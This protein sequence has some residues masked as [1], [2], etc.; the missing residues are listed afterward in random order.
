MFHK[1]LLTLTSGA[2]ALTLLSVQPAL[3]QESG[4]DGRAGQSGGA[5]RTERGPRQNRRAS[6]AATPT[7]GENAATV[8]AMLTTASV[9]CRVLEATLVGVTAEEHPTYEASCVDG[10]GYLVIGATPPQTFNCL[11]LAGQAETSRLRDPEADVGQQCTLPVN[12]DPLPVLSGYARQAGIDCTVDRAGAIGKNNTGQL[13]YEIGCAER[14]GYWIEK[15]DAGWKT[16]PCWSL[17]LQG[18][19]C[20]YSTPAETLGAWKTVLAGTEAAPCDVQ[21]ARR[22]GRDAQGLTVYE[23]KCG[24]GDGYLAR[25]GDTF[26]AQRV[27]PCATAQTIGGGCTLTPA[28]AAPATSSEQ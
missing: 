10:P 18:V 5:D 9:D 12:L 21:Q 15:A 23:V 3:A 25:V 24:V 19:T 14:D 8:Q 27:H 2:L 22:V 11:E 4:E 7:A 1:T 6:G 20:R 16:S 28:S 13:I 17:S 26:T